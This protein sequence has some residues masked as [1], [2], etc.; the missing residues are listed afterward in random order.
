MANIAE[1]ASSPENARHAAGHDGASDSAHP[2]DLPAIALDRGAPVGLRPCSLA[3]ARL[4]HTDRATRSTRKMSEETPPVKRR[5]AGGFPGREQAHAAQPREKIGDAGGVGSV[6]GHVRLRRW[7][8]ARRTARTLA[9]SRRDK[10]CN[11]THP[12]ASRDSP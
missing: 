1:P 10:A 2:F 3:N 7:V 5:D 8:Y 4:T 9:R 6:C 11:L 12:S